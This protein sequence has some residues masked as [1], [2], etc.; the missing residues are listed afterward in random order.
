MKRL[1]REPFT[2]QRQYEFTG[3]LSCQESHR[4]LPREDSGV[5]WTAKLSTTERTRPITL[6]QTGMFLRDLPH[7]ADGQTVRVQGHWVNSSRF[8]VTSIS[9]VPTMIP[10]TNQEKL[11]IPVDPGYFE[12][13]YTPRIE[14]CSETAFMIIDYHIAVRL[15]LS[16]GTELQL[17]YETESAP[18]GYARTWH[19]FVVIDGYER[20]HTKNASRL[21]LL[22]A[23]YENHPEV[24]PSKLWKA[25]DVDPL[26]RTETSNQG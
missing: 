10:G 3:V 19:L 6:V 22:K 14:E 21:E 5:R 24:P 23:F 25:L 13:F 8:Q 7:V 18:P 11:Y 16:N 26:R 17:T 12:A 20:E 1:A 15:L 9:R 2:G 4:L